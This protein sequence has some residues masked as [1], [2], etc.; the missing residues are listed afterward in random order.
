MK[1]L[2]LCD[3][4]PPGQHGGIGTSV[5]L[6]ARQMA[7]MGHKVVVAG[8][9]PLGYGGADEFTDEGVKVYR[10]RLG[11]DGKWFEHRDW[12]LV[13]IV[14]ML[15][16]IT[17]LLERDIKKSLPVY[18][19][20]LEQLIAAN[21]IDIVE[22]PDYNDYIKFCGGYV[23]FPQL[24]VP[25]VV[26]MNGSMTYFAYLAD[27]PIAVNAIKMEQAILK[28]AA[29][30]SSASKYTAEKSAAWFGYDKP[31]EILHNGINTNVPLSNEHRNTS[32]VIF[33]GSL[34]EK[35]GIYQLAKAWNMVNVSIPDARLLIL[36]KGDQQKVIQYLSDSARNTVTFLGHVDTETLY[37]HLS[38][39]AIS[40]F[41]SYAEAFALAPLEAMLC[42]TAVI[43]SNRTSGP[44]LIENEMNGLLVDPDDIV[45]MA[46]AMVYLLT[47]THDR[48]RLAKA[49]RETVIDKFDIAKIAT[50]NIDFYQRILKHGQVS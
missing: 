49:G 26:K 39:S 15:L 12:L 46:A 18:Q 17:G 42:G 24:S 29:A 33:T 21:Q 10:F 13:R 40:I 23:P 50:L 34:M 16:K 9:Y 37:R 36:G 35:K 2:Y 28:Q 27:K 43:N 3:E 31:I 7:K 32:Q 38:A 30:V 47:A 4:Y 5:Q 1:I 20:Q 48:E 25:V 44:E 11:M 19:H 14:R 41:P 45:Q 8:L 22:M 6:L